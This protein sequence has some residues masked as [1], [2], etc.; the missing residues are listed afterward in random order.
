[1]AVEFSSCW[2]DIVTDPFTG[3]ETPVTRCR[4]VGGDTVDYASDSDVPSVL[5]P[6]LGTDLTGECWYLTSASTSYVILVQYADGSAEIGFDTDPTTPGGIV[7]IGPTIPRCTSEPAAASDPVAEAWAYVMSYV[8]DPPQ[9]EL[10][11]VPG[12]GITGLDT[13]LGLTVPDDHAATLASGTS[14][15]E[16]EI[17]VDAVVVAWGDG[18]IDTYPADDT[19][20]AGYPDGGAIHVY[21]VKN[22]EGA[23]LTVEYDWTA[24]WRLDGGT[25][26]P[27]DVPNTATTIGY[28]VAEVVSRLGD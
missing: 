15:L 13:Y 16:V 7:A 9:P 18:S 10:S 11:P 14:S 1:M 24:R 22:T 20:L 2:T 23:T 12:Q 26:T 25:W 28:P 4:I 6:N 3:S 27:L 19:I 5:Y 17:A 8:H 21:E